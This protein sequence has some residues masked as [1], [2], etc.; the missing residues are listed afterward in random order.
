METVYLKFFDAFSYYI[1][2]PT[3]RKKKNFKISK[4]LTNALSTQHK[5]ADSLHGKIVDVKM[6]IA[7]CSVRGTVIYCSRV[8]TVP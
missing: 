3:Y 1:C 4:V 8:Q 5:D 7:Y 2:R 6:Y